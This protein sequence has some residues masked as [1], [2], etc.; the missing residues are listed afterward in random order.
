MINRFGPGVGHLNYLAVPGGGIF[1]VLFVPV[2]TNYFPGWEIQLYLTSHFCLGVG[3]WTAIFGKCQNPAYAPPPLSPPPPR[4]LD[5]DR[6]ISFNKQT[7]DNHT[8][9]QSSHVS[10]VGYGTAHFARGILNFA[11]NSSPPPPNVFAPL[12]GSPFA[13]H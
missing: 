7:E 3:N 13:G 10:A 12:A 9:S 8:L 6:C 4:R 5:I 2:T 1:E 11:L